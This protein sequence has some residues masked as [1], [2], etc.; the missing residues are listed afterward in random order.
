MT[1]KNDQLH[2]STCSMAVLPEPREVKVELAMGDPCLKWEYMRASGAGGQGVNTTDSAVRLTHLPTG[3]AVE[4]QEQRS[5]VW[6]VWQGRHNMRDVSR[7]EGCNTGRGF[8]ISDHN[9][10]TLVSHLV[11]PGFAR[12]RH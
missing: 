7:R 9:L 3:T 10:S 8:I 11:G 4:A 2:T 5:Q 1:A 12:W 6:E